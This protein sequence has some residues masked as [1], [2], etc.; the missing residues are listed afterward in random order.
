MF[1]ALS[2]GTAWL[3]LSDSCSLDLWVSLS[4]CLLHGFGYHIVKDWVHGPGI[5]VKLTLSCPAITLSSADPLI[6][7]AL[8]VAVIEIACPSW[9]S[10]VSRRKAFITAPA[11]PNCPVLCEKE[12]WGRTKILWKSRQTLNTHLVDFF[13]GGEYVLYLIAGLFYSN[14]PV[15]H[16]NPTDF[17][18]AYTFPTKHMVK[19]VTI[20]REEQL[21][22]FPIYALHNNIKQ[23]LRGKRY[24][25]RVVFFSS[26]DTVH[27]FAFFLTSWHENQVP[28]WLCPC[29]GSLGL[30]VHAF[31]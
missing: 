18:G 30:G 13:L 29:V 16:K 11:P 2:L 3:P 5:L 22:Y 25:L 27:L 12:L 8:N 24:L 26:K 19:A 1:S 9:N 4:V 17:T 21:A 28:L 10:T 15:L 23:I 7:D 14:P 31:V 20:E 6:L